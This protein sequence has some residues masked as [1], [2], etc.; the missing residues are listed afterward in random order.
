MMKDTDEMS[1]DYARDFKKHLRFEIG[2][3]VYLKA[4]L[5]RKCPMVVNAF[6]ITSDDYDYACTWMTSQKERVTDVFIDKILV[7]GTE[8]C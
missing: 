5:K 8:P 3:L 2:Q 7:D 1:L 4:D 6:L